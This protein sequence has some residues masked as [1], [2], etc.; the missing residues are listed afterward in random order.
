MRSK[1]VRILIVDV[2]SAA[3]RGMRAVLGTQARW[4]VCAEAA[5]GAE[6]VRKAAKF[7]PDIVLMDP[8]LPDVNGLEALRQIANSHL[9]SKV[10]LFAEG[11]SNGSVR[12]ALRVGARGYV[13][14]SDSDRNLLAAVA[15]GRLGQKTG[16]PDV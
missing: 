10:L 8:A 16:R 9:G 11:D 1:P 15:A 3:R 2:Q 14:K 6:A 5:T 7:R 4:E 12:E 13:L